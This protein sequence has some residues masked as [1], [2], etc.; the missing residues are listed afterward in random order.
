MTYFIDIQ[1]A[2]ETELPLSEELLTDLACLALRDQTTS[3]ELTIRLVA[4]AEMVYLNT[5]YRNINKTTNV[6][7]FPCL[8]P[9]EIE[10]ECPLL[11]DVIICPE[12][13]A[14]ESAQ[15]KK[16]IQEYWS[17]IVI[18]GV[19]HLLGYDHIEDKDALIMQKIEITLLAELGYQNPYDIE[20]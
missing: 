10:L 11:G 18:H 4:P 2:C 19:L 7:A 8:L 13:V 5:T 1:N 3:A 17:H 6:L 20:E 15:A 16:N 12:V 14:E 9:E